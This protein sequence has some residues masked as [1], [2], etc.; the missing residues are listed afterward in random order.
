[1]ASD[2]TNSLGD[3]L[4]Q[5]RER[6]GITIEQVASATKINVRLLHSLEA[7][8]YAD[9]PAKP[10]IRGFVTSYARFVGLD[11]NEILT[12]FN[13]FID[14]KALD[15][16]TKD[17]GHSGYVFEKR[18]GDQSRRTLSYVLGTFIAVGLIAVLIFKPSFKSRKHRHADKLR[19]E[20]PETTTAT[21]VPSAIPSVA[22][23]V[24]PSVTPSAVPS[25]KPSPSPKAKPLPSPTASPTA[26]V[27][28]IPPASPSPTS[29]PA[30]SPSPTEKSD[31][32]NSGVNIAPKSITHKLIIKALADVWVRYRC[33]ERPKMK[34]MLRKDR[35]LVLRAEKQVVLQVS[36]PDSV[37]IASNTRGTQVASAD[38]TLKNVDDS[39]TLGYPPQVADSAAEIFQ[40]ENTLP[41]TP[42]PE[43][44][45]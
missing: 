38:T 23:S 9:L 33:D 3:F 27:A 10:F 41:K 45:P 24:A 34:F 26:A 13:R 4:R 1:M 40:G 8:H 35:L 39:S 31:P 16:P 25:P 7:D 6:R 19:D 14:E 21:A 42:A 20:T 15:R 2:N 32:L 12:R 43:A 28:V 30:P 11:P 44:T 17:A 18:E 36:N 22:P 5:E 37:Q 29:S